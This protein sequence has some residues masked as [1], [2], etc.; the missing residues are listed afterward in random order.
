[1]VAQKV[2]L[3]SGLWSHPTL[4]GYVWAGLRQGAW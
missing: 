4:W 3:P 1:L 2:D